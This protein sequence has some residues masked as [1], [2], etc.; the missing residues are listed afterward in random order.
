[1]NDIIVG[2]VR[3]INEL[4]KTCAYEAGH[5]ISFAKAGCGKQI[6][7]DFT[8]KLLGNKRYQRYTFQHGTKLLV[9]LQTNAINFKPNNPLFESE[10]IS[11]LISHEGEIINPLLHPMD[12]PELMEEK[13]MVRDALQM[14]IGHLDGTFS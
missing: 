11:I 4:L 12:T 14:L 5:P 2:L 8:T 10:V 6:D 1:M 13:T 9:T 3:R 7:I